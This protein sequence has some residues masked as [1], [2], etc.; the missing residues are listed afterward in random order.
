M[1]LIKQK[2]IT[3]KGFVTNGLEKYCINVDPYITPENLAKVITENLNNYKKIK[4]NDD[5]FNHYSF[6]CA[7][8]KIKEIL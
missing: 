1:E 3:T 2:I 4:D 5:I 7:A 6:L 8:N